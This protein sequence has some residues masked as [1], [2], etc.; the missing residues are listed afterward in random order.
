MI[1]AMPSTPAVA[2][3]APAA[4]QSFPQSFP[5]IELRQYTLHPGQRDGATC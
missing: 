3:D 5:I 4:L 2:V 1:Q